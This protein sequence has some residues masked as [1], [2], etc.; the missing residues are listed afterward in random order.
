M[1]Q[2]DQVFGSLAVHARR[3]VEKPAIEVERL[4]GG[5]K[6]V[7]I[8]L[9]RQI[10]D[11]LVLPH[12]RRRPVEH[13]SVALGREEQAKEE[14]DGC[15]LPGAVRPQK[16]E[17]LAALNLEVERPQCSLFGPSPEVAV[18]LRQLPRFD[19]DIIGHEQPP[20]SKG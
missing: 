17:D 19:N 12:I 14:L 16:S 11:F 6:S 7:E 18:N 20:S 3:H 4:L 13:E 5:E 9:F 8:R 1:D 15:R 2:V 10:A